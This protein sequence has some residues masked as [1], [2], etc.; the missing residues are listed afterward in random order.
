M[1]G[2]L[3]VGGVS[4]DVLHLPDGRTVEAPGGAG[5]YTALGAAQAGARVMLC[6]P[7]PEPM[8]D[9]L[10]PAAE[11]L[12]WRG[13]R[14]SAAGLMRLEIAH[15]GGGRA[16][17]VAAH[18]GA[19]AHFTPADLPAD[20]PAGA[21]THIAALGSALRQLEF[22]RAVRRRGARSGPPPSRGRRG[23]RAPSPES[24]WAGR[25]PGP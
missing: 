7:R 13:P 19:L 20:L 8:P 6:A 14:I 15:H 4:L 11:R 24:C 10:R 5:L 18:W 25:W 23:W 22:A 1:S 17:L 16:T 3:V 2:L 12:D 21:I 9:V